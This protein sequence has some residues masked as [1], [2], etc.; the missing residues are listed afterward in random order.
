MHCGLVIR[1][2]WPNPAC[3]L[4]LNLVRRLA[5]YTKFLMHTEGFYGAVAHM[6]D[7]TFMQAGVMTAAPKNALLTIVEKLSSAR[8]MS[9]ASLATSVPVI[10]MATP[11]SASFRAGAS[12]T[13]SPVIATM[14]PISRR[15]RT[16]SCASSSDGLPYVVPHQEAT[17]VNMWTTHVANYEHCV[18]APDV[19]CTMNH[20]STRLSLYTCC[21]ATS[22][23]H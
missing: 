6:M 16:I 21:P 2:S 3:S 18:R 8:T 13:P 19:L 5:A 22:R 10:P 1:S 7:V 20:V 4:E 17:A 12:F 14:W 9:L 23:R 15:R 11:M